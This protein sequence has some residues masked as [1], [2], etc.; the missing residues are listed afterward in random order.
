MTRA[1]LSRL[2]V[3]SNGGCHAKGRSESDGG[4]D[5]ILRFMDDWLW[6]LALFWMAPCGGGGPSQ[7][8]AGGSTGTEATEK[9]NKILDSAPTR[10][11]IDTKSS[12][13]LWIAGAERAR[14]VRRVPRRRGVK[15]QASVNKDVFRRFDDF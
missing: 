10:G 2:W 12:R 5:F 14:C 8:R 11:Y 1:S 15:C 6:R 3:R 13:T 4:A 7:R 9:R